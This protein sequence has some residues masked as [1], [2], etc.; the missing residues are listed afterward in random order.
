MEIWRELPK[1]SA[2]NM[3]AVVSRKR[4]MGGGNGGDLGFFTAGLERRDDSPVK[5]E[6]R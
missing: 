4:E 6:I 1:E 2:K 3:R 5:V